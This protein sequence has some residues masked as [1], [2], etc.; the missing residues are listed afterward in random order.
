MNRR[1][2]VDCNCF[3]DFKAVWEC[4]MLENNQELLETQNNNFSFTIKPYEIKTFKLE[5]K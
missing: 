3:G 5:I 4:D 1:T 2:K